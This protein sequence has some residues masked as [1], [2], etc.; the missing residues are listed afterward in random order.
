MCFNM[1]GS[2]DMLDNKKN[3]NEKAIKFIDN[4]IDE[5]TADIDMIINKI[6]TYKE[7]ISK[8]EVVI[9][10]LNSKNDSFSLFSPNSKEYDLGSLENQIEDIK[11][12]ASILENE[13]S[14]LEMKISQAKEIKKLL[15]NWEAPKKIKGFN[16]LEI[17]EKDRQRIARDLHDSTVQNLTSLIHK[18][19]LCSRLVDIDP[20]RAKL[21]LNTMSITL[22][23][24]INEI[25][26]IIYNLKPMSLDD[27]GLTITIERYIN[28][29]L[30]YHDINI[31][32]THNNDKKGILPVIKL[33]VFRMIQEACNNA[34]KHSEA[35]DINIDLKYHDDFITLTVKDNGR[36]FDLD[37]KKDYPSSDYHG[38]GL[39]IMKERVYLL[40]GTIKI[41]SSLNKG[42]IVTITIP[43]S[44]SKGEDI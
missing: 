36:G 34:I 43:I 19:E 39:P 35:T 18:S 44:M 31:S 37:N 23:S 9:D 20:V 8:K 41:Q 22:K 3:T 14:Q 15:N 24:V 2:K 16:M 27:L 38:Y 1:K 4:L 40:S 5:Y 32:F 17:Q 12:Q 29:L 25:R 11:E 6:K 13:K 10:L 30:M 26:E 33:S 42:T 28:Q 7:N 21:E